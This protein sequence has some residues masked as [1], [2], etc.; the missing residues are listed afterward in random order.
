MQWLDVGCGRGDL[1]GIAGK[2]FKQAMGCDPS[3]GMLS[4]ESPFEMYKQSSPDKLP[5]ADSSLNFITAVCVYHHVHGEARALLTKEIRR[6]LAPG[7]LCCIVEHNP[8]NPVTQAIVKR[9]PVDVDAE[10]LTA[11]AAKS[12]FRTYGFRVVD[13]DHFLY[14]PERLYSKAGALERT[15]RKL[16]FGGQYAL[17]L[18]SPQ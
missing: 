7:G 3:F 9:C 13:T 15:L 6:V 1:L 14:F 17:L 18:R 11:S 8:W 16:P 4:F 2:F 12:L 10:L 5:F